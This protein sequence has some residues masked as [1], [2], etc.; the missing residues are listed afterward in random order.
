MVS[1]SAAGSITSMSR[2]HRR[3]CHLLLLLLP[4]TPLLL[5]MLLANTSP[6]TTNR[7]W[8]GVGSDEKWDVVV[9]ASIAAVAVRRWEVCG[10][11]ERGVVAR[12]GRRLLISTPGTTG[13][14]GHPGATGSTLCEDGTQLLMSSGGLQ[15]KMRRRLLSSQHRNLTGRGTARLLPSRTNLLDRLLVPVGQVY[16]QIHRLN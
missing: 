10:V 15:G 13:G 9:T 1:D 11:V 8:G 3:H 6:T 5:L 7:S 2:S 16:Q 12:G 14:G 4:A